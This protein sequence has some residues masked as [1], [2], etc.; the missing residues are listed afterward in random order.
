MRVVANLFLVFFAANA[1]L[2]MALLPFFLTKNWSQPL[3]LFFIII[4]SSVGGIFVDMSRG[5][6]EQ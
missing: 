4:M 2:A 1:L 3:F 6:G 5:T